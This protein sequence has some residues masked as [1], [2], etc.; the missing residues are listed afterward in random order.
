M[1]MWLNNQINTWIDAAHSGYEKHLLFGTNHD[2]ILYKKTT[3]F[4]LILCNTA[5]TLYVVLYLKYLYLSL[6]SLLLFVLG[7]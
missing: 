2:W 5:Y 6:L 7:Q 3:Y 4:W 1:G